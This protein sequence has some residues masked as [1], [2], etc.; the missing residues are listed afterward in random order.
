MK[1]IGAD[2]IGGSLGE[3][4]SQKRTDQADK[5][6]LIGKHTENESLP[7]TENLKI[8]RF[9]DP[10]QPGCKYGA[11]QNQNPGNNAQYGKKPDGPG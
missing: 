11:D 10:G 6:I 3:A 1:K 2:Q 4:G 8:D 7:G 5:K 9:T